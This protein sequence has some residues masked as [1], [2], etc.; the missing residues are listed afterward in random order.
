MFSLI[1]AVLVGLAFA[2]F[3]TQNTSGVTVNLFGSQW[4]GMP[5]YLIAVGA[6]LFGLVVAWIINTL[7]WISNALTLHGKESKIKQVEH[8]MNNLQQKVHELELEN[9]KLQGE[10]SQPAVER[11]ETTAY[12]EP[13]RAY[14]QVERKPSWLDKIRHSFAPKHP[15]TY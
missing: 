2:Y 11:Y 4:A 8:S 7:D 13:R 3:A 10:D 15:A 14:F 1:L 12:Q 9:A 6:L 5:L